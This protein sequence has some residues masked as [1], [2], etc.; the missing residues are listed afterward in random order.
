MRDERG[1]S[2]IWFALFTAFVVAPLLAL[3]TNYAHLAR[4]AARLQS[5]ADAACEDAAYSAVDY[6][7]YRNTGTVTYKPGWYVLSTAQTTF[8]NV[9]SGHYRAEFTPMLNVRVDY[10]NAL[11]YCTATASVPLYILGTSKTLTRQSASA[12]RFSRR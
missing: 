8:W 5:A 2:L 3:S 4:I 1:Q 6:E 10:P 9:L 7:A 12:I 11:V